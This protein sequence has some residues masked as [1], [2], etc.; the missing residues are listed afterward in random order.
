MRL[1]VPYDVSSARGWGGP[2]ER[3]VPARPSTAT[4]ALSALVRHRGIR[5]ME[6]GTGERFVRRVKGRR[7]MSVISFGPEWHEALTVGPPRSRLVFEGQPEDDAPGDTLFKHRRSG[8]YDT[9]FDSPVKLRPVES[10]PAADISD[11]PPTPGRV[12]QAGAFWRRASEDSFAAAAA[13]DDDGDEVEGSLRASISDINSG[14]NEGGN[15]VEVE[16]FDMPF[17]I[18]SP[19]QAN[20]LIRVEGT[21]YALTLP[22]MEEIV[23]TVGGQTFINLVY[24]YALEVETSSPIVGALDSENKK[25]I[26]SNY[27]RKNDLQ[28]L[29]VKSSRKLRNYDMLAGLVVLSV[30]STAVILGTTAVTGMGIRGQWHLANIAWDKIVYGAQKAKQANEAILQV[31]DTTIKAICP[32]ELPS[33]T[34]NSSAIEKATYWANE[35]LKAAPVVNGALGST[36]P[37]LCSSAVAAR[38]QH[39]KTMGKVMRWTWSAVPAGITA[40]SSVVGIRSL[41]AYFFKKEIAYHTLQMIDLIETELKEEGLD[42]DNME[43]EAVE[44][45]IHDRIKERINRWRK[46]KTPWWKKRFDSLP[47][48]TSGRA[49]PKS[50]AESPLAPAA[51]AVQNAPRSGTRRVV[52]AGSIFDKD[53][54]TGQ[55]YYVGEEE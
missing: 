34:V 25:D 27:G 7:A 28:R 46:H 21:T 31:Y 49:E 41:K 35:G 32:I 39:L 55:L 37:D 24:M 12:H 3:H 43:Y 18:S 8:D 16:L 42:L 6:A 51:E 14:L 50:A 33:L 2:L 19:D 20:L 5:F 22:E 53:I 17:H 26:A 9:G 10:A 48:K 4:R 45:I 23:E 40:I 11:A 52:N 29:V 1:A 54:L 44:H 15:V 36:L 30:A 13:D 47:I 38:A